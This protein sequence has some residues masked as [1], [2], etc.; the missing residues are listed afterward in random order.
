[1]ISHIRCFTKS[2]VNKWAHIS[3]M[4]LNQP[5]YAW[6]SKCTLNLVLE[7]PML[8]NPTDMSRLAPFSHWSNRDK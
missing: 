7:K 1:M 2:T 6:F 8:I 5:D 3:E 4:P